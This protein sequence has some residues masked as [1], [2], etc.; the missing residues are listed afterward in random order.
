MLKF[1]LDR[2]IK[3]YYDR[4]TFTKL[5]VEA[6]FKSEINPRYYM[7]YENELKPLIAYLYDNKDVEYISLNFHYS[8]SSLY[9]FFRNYNEILKCTKEGFYEVDT[10]TME[11]KQNLMEYKL[12]KHNYLY[13]PF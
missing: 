12:G 6:H 10:T 7:V 5:E 9:C 8:M 2:R 4:K 1:D 11:Y 3:Y 13:T